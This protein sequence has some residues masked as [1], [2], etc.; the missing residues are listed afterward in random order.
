MGISS[1]EYSSGMFSSSTK[2]GTYDSSDK[3]LFG[4]V[5]SSM[6]NERALLVG[7]VVCSWFSF[8]FVDSF[9]ADSKTGS[10]AVPDSVETCN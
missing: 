5:T 3:R 8:S 6:S 1:F 7:S 4:D 9:S 2:L 10:L